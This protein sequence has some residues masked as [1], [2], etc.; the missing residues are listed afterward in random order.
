MDYSTPSPRVCSNSC[1][2]SWWCHPTI[3]PSATLFSSHLPSLPASGSFPESWHF[4]SGGQSI[5]ASA[6]VLPMKKIQGWFPLGLTGLS[7]CCPRDSPSL[8]Q[9]HDLKASVLQCSVFFM[10][11]LSHPYMTIGK[12]IALTRQT[13]LSK[14]M[15]VIF[16][17]L[18][19]VVMTF[20][21][22]SKCLLISWL[23]S[24]SAVFRSPRN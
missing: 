22:R 17:M 4:A 2:L 11:Q 12:T 6:S 10:V 21:P 16:N 14:V 13:F 18:P 7:P 15:S 24:P 1:P 20:L 23:Q 5:G 8:L 19:R 9:H 3:S